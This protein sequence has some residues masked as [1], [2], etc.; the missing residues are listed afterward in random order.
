MVN[1]CMMA[2]G[3]LSSGENEKGFDPGF[4]LF[5]K[6]IPVCGYASPNGI[7]MEEKPSMVV[8]GES[9]SKQEEEP[10]VVES[11]SSP[12]FNKDHEGSLESEEE[13]MRSSSEV[14]NRKDGD[15]D[16]S[17]SEGKNGGEKPVLKKPDKLLPCPRC[18]SMDTKFCYYN[19]YNVNQP[20][21]FCKNCQRYW[22]AGGTLRNVPVGAGRRKNKHTAAVASAASSHYRQIRSASETALG[23]RTDDPDGVMIPCALPAPCVRPLKLGGSRIQVLPLDILDSGSAAAAA[24]T[25]GSGSAS[26]VLNF[27]PDGHSNKIP[28]DGEQQMDWQQQ[29]HNRD[30]ISCGSSVTGDRDAAGHMNP[31]SQPHAD[32]LKWPNGPMAGAAGVPFFAGPWPYAWNFAAAPAPWAPMSWSV[33]SRPQFGGWAPAPWIAAPWAAAAAATTAYNSAEPAPAS[34]CGSPTLGKR[35][36]C[37]PEGKTPNGCLWVPKTLRIDDPG[38]AAKS[39][40]WTTLGVGNKPES[41]IS[42]GGMFKAFQPKSDGSS[43]NSPFKPEPASQAALRA[44]PAAFSRSISFQESN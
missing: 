19:N 32:A 27:G 23:V 12:E 8:A 14:E 30:E 9:E 15:D 16:N 20:R 24:S 6:T 39:S 22:T 28:G 5:G 40:I 38:E 36:Q 37:E 42:G 10:I 7:E 21:H 35:A 34:D 31:P 26:T 41:P 29:Q 44:N 3:C 17:N 1:D 43:K 4:K 33:V 13:E 11:S 18:E 2:N 25:G